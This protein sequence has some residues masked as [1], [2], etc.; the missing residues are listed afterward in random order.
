MSHAQSI[1]MVCHSIFAIVTPSGNWIFSLLFVN[2]AIISCHTMRFRYA[3]LLAYASSWFIS[4]VISLSVT[5]FN[6]W[7]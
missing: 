2:C 4:F 6:A 1:S 5:S 3:P 7:L